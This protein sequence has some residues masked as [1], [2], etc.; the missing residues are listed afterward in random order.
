MHI[1]YAHSK[2]VYQGLRSAVTP[3]AKANGF[4]R[5]PGTQAGWQKPLNPE[6]LL[7][8]KFE[9]YRM[10]NPDTGHAVTGLVQ[11]EPRSG[12]VTA[13]SIRQSS[14]SGCLVRSELDQLA[15][16]QGAINQ[17]RPHLPTYLEKDFED[18]SLLGHYLRSLYDPAPHYQ[19]GEYVKFSYYS[20]EDVRELAG[21]IVAVL[22]VALERFLEGRVSAP[23][24]PT[25]AHLRAKW[26]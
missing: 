8:F 18:D 7:G 10:A 19:E 23:I 6:Q 2:A 22:P 14:F 9:G 11:L 13:R 12:E 24:D 25:P 20:I 16:I 21:F 17:R 26:L 4:H 1:E 5:W 15:R 3:W